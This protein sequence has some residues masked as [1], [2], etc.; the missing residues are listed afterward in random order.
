[1]SDI[2]IS[3]SRDE[4]AR[5]QGLATA[6]E[7]RGW[8]VWWDPDIRTG[9]DFDASIA[10]ALQAA[11]CV[12]VVWSKRSVDSPWVKDEAEVGR[13]R[14][15]LVPV[16]IDA[17]DRPLGFGRLQTVDLIDWDGREPH[18]EFEK[19]AGDIAN[20]LA[21]GRRPGTGAIASASRTP[22]AP[23]SPAS[24]A[25]APR[26]AAPGF[27]ANL[28]RHRLVFAS[29]AA[30]IVALLGYVLYPFSTVAPPADDRVPPRTAAIPLR[31]P[32]ES[33]AWPTPDDHVAQQVDRCR[34]MWKSQEEARAANPGNGQ[35][36][37]SQA[38]CAMLLLDYIRI[39]GEKARFSDVVD[40]LTPVLHQTLD[41]SRGARAADILAH[42]G[43]ATFLKWRDGERGLQ[44]EGYYRRALEQDADNPFANAMWGHW[45]LWQRGSL[46]EAQAHFTRALS[47]G[48]ERAFVR[49]LQLAALTLYSDAPLQ[50]EAVRVANEMRGNQEPPPTNDQERRVWSEY[51]DI[52]YDHIANGHEKEAFLAA[53]PPAD[54]LA[55]FRWLFPE[56]QVPRDKLQ[57]WVL[58]LATFQ[59]RNGERA[60]ARSNYESLRADLTSQHLSGTLLTQAEAGLRRVSVP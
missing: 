52:Y 19:L 5:V 13:R 28:H 2:F 14:G 15:V 25:T 36:L 38:D 21:G 3:Y 33:A 29:A 26:P 4:R 57:L 46:A 18:P 59:E 27:A 54:H 37:A 60:A 35:L 43:W 9:Q 41:V 40:T 8:S 44:P 23:A 50:F 42:L 17:V 39:T 56:S 31:I 53:L 20:I 6:L 55:T 34:D 58:F 49:Q 47:S 12:V 16:R 24:T 48:R 51:W 1:M 22:A 45:I 32:E 30:A 11:R 7:R 10:A